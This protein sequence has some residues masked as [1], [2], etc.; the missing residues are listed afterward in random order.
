MADD[1]DDHGDPSKTENNETDKTPVKASIKG[2]ETNICWLLVLYTLQS[3][4]I[5]LVMG[6]PI[7]IQEMKLSSFNDQVS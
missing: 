6:I 4:P 5:G 2:D 3:V 1:S 7:I